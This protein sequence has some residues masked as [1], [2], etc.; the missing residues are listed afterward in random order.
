MDS[1]T[2]RA[3]N[4]PD[5]IADAHR[6]GGFALAR[7][8]E[9]LVGRNAPKSLT[10][11]LR[12]SATL[13]ELTG[14]GDQLW[15]LGEGRCPFA[16]SK[17][18]QRTTKEPTHV[19]PNHVFFGCPPFHGCPATPPDVTSS[20]I[21][22]PDL[23]ECPID[24]AVLDSGS[25]AH[26]TL[27]PRVTAV[28]GTWFNSA[29]GRVE[30]VPDDAVDRDGDGLLDMMAGHGNFVSGVI[31]ERA[32]A[33]RITS[34]GHRSHHA[35]YTEWELA[36]TLRMEGAKFGV[37]NLAIAGMTYR[38]R[39][40]AILGNAISAL[41]AETVLV[42]SAGNMGSTVPHWPGA[43]RRVICVGAV[44]DTKR[45]VKPSRASFSNFGAW[46]DCCCGGVDVLG[47][48]VWWKG[49]V[50]DEPNGTY[51][52]NGFAKWSG[53]SF[54]APKVAAAIVQIA[55]DR[56]MAPRLAAAHLLAGSGG[57]ATRW[58]PDMGVELDLR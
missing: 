46:V 54:S 13:A 15:L 37:I 30:V 50:E 38:N 42:A 31:A 1:T 47:A 43:F 48:S 25:I 6:G 32:A 22:L 4:D 34:F 36:N 3:L 26:A 41:P 20:V 56:A 8:G 27:A 40:P 19:G 45:R 18:L 35:T 17:E 23:A 2:R 58:R 7:R 24:V 14:G 12:K 29:T 51:E 52:F 5:I 39:P 21:T 49:G 11:R 55:S 44:D 53:T 28:Q 9:L 10:D 16:L 57:V 33:A